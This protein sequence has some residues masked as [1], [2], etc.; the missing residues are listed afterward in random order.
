ML[1]IHEAL[2]IL[3]KNKKKYTAEQANNILKLLY[4][5]GEIAYLQ[6]K[7]QNNHEKSNNICE[8]IYRR[9]S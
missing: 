4:Q 2:K 9:A 7:Q 5:L 6:F 8:G 3:N 1:T